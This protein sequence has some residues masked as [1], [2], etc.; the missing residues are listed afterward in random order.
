MLEVEKLQARVKELT[1]T[2]PSLSPRLWLFSKVLLD[3]STAQLALRVSEARRSGRVLSLWS[4]AQHSGTVWAALPRLLRLRVALTWK[5][6]LR[7]GECAGPWGM[8]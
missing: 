2:A 5:E 4:Q 3:Q 1:F 8:G 7:E 6:M